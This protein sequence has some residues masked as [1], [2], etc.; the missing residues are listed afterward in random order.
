[1]D[2]AGS[3]IAGPG[4]AAKSNGLVQCEPISAVTSAAGSVEHIHETNRAAVRRARKMLMG[5][6]AAEKGPCPAGIKQM[7][8][9]HTARVSTAT[10][11][12]NARRGS[13][14]QKYRSR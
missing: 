3:G 5:P 14:R 2:D 6:K 10:K 7:L 11:T 13:I 1:M 9:K 12:I 8:E 4:A